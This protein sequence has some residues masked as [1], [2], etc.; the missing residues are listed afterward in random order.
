MRFSIYSALAISLLAS[1]APNEENWG[2]KI[3]KAEC[4]FAER[5]D[6]ANFY[7]VYDDVELCRETKE[8]AYS[9]TAS[10]LATCTFDKDSA[11]LCLDGLG[12]S[13]KSIGREYDALIAPCATVWSC[14]GAAVDTFDTATPA[15]TTPL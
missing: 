10:S 4:K 14:G 5:C 2:K 7:F 1:C 3:A 8:A 15:P 9:A 12:D 13:C 11:K 6:A